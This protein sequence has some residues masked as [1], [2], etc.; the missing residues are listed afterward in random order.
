MDDEKLL[1]ESLSEH[2]S[3][4]GDSELNDLQYDQSLIENLFYKTSVSGSFSSFLLNVCY[5]RPLFLLI[6][7]TLLKSQFFFQVSDSGPGASEKKSPEKASLRPRP[8]M[9]RGYRLCLASLKSEHCRIYL[10]FEQKPSFTVFRQNPEAQHCTEG[11]FTSPGL[12]AEL[13]SVRLARVTINSLTVPASS[14][15]TTLQKKSSRGKPPPS[16]SKKWLESTFTSSI[17]L[18]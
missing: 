5:Y 1:H 4:C 13:S 16:A 12:S 2:S 14:S 17:L 18:P 3:V 15:G 10:A 7:A 11:A 9:R 8:K 6:M